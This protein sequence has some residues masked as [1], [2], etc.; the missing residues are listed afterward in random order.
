MDDLVMM[1][2]SEPMTTSLAIAEGTQ[3][4][5]ASVIKLVRKYHDDLSEFGSLGFEIQVMREDGRGGQKAEIAL[6][7]EPQATLLLT[8]MRNSD[9][10][11][12]FKKKLVKAFFEMRDQLIEG[13]GDRKQVD[14][15]MRHQRGITNPH[16]LDI[17]Y[18]LDLTKLMM[19]PNRTGMKI[20]QRLTGVELEDLVED[21]DDRLLAAGGLTPS[22]VAFSRDG[23]I[24]DEGAWT[25]IEAIHNAYADYCAGREL[26]V[27]DVS[28]FCRDLRQLYPDIV[29]K[30][31][32]QGRRLWGY[33]N[34][35]L[36]PAE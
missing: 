9:I 15:N 10:V 22:V 11:R 36:L 5:H 19:K 18:S 14:V 23:L 26:P 2:E 34:L 1:R 17:K 29:R 6:L 32:S 25:E 13:Q 27:L 4:P 31:S 35:R 7:N 30:R 3:N 28:R 8:Y 33:T 12:Q 24:D 20:L 21:M 16:G